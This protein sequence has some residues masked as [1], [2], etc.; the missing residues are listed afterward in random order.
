MMR[1]RGLWLAVT[2]VGVFLGGLTASVGAEDKAASASGTWKGTLMR[3]DGQ[4]NEFTLKLKQDGNK[5]TGVHIGGPNNQ[6][7]PI[8]EGTIKDGT[9]S[10][11][12]TRER[13][14]QKITL[15]YGGKLAGDAIKG[16]IDVNFNGQE[17]TLDWEAKR[18]AAKK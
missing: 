18:E 9:L 3:P 12:V 11:N 5:L 2:V 7:G 14:G 1:Q 10:F 17:F 16:K 4:T 6:E 13:D 8:N 15:K